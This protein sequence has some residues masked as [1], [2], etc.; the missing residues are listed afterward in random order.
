M[1]NTCLETCVLP[2]YLLRTWRCI[3]LVLVSFG[4]YAIHSQSSPLLCA[5]RCLKTKGRKQDPL[6]P[7]SPHREWLECSVQLP[8]A[9]GSAIVGQE[10]Q[11]PLGALSYK[12]RIGS[13]TECESMRVCLWPDSK[14][15]AACLRHWVTR[16]SW[17]LYGW[18][19]YSPAFWFPS[20][21]QFWH[22]KSY[23]IGNPSILGKLGWL[24]TLHGPGAHALAGCSAQLWQQPLSCLPCASPAL[25]SAISH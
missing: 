24:A 22:W 9:T 8:G 7:E 15:M 16:K 5:S 6:N 10:G 2:H 11:V 14:F 3:F 13:G 4:V 23:V 17:R 25:H 1:E 19:K 20:L 18:I 21:S 12:Y